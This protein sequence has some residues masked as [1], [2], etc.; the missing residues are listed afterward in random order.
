LVGTTGPDPDEEGGPPPKSKLRSTNANCSA[1]AI[2]R[3]GRSV[4]R[5]A[6]ALFC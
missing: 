6:G 4:R 2:D 5:P 1:F 3:G